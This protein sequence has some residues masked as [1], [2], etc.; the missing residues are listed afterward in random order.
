MWGD[1]IKKLRKELGLT[2]TECAQITG[3]AQSSISG[4]EK[5]ENSDLDYIAK[6]CKYANIPLWQ[7]F[8]PDDVKIL[9]DEDH[10]ALYNHYS[11]LPGEVKKIAIEILSGINKAYNHGI[12]STASIKK[13][14]HR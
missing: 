2:Q 9:E 6:L 7:F 10:V 5:S 3:H 13:K 14:N 8:A 1:K 12:E 4:Y 11:H